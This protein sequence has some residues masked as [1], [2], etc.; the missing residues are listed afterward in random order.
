MGSRTG[1][2]RCVSGPL[3]VTGDSA[4]SQRHKRHLLAA[5]QIELV[6]QGLDGGKGVLGE[7]EVT[8]DAA[9]GSR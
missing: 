2:A 9:A 1:L 6:E 7:R 5:L 3:R 8:G 4:A